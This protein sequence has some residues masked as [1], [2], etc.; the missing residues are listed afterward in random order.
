MR[1]AAFVVCSIAASACGGE[2]QFF[3]YPPLQN[4]KS[5]LIAVLTP[6][7][8]DVF[9]YEPEH[10]LAF[11]TEYP[12]DTPRLE[13]MTLSSRLEDEGLAAGTIVA[14][15]TAQRTVAELPSVLE[16]SAA[17]TANGGTWEE[18]SALD[19]R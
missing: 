14:S 2:K 18:A 10:A 17:P 5:A 3:H 1:R 12:I 7:S 13:A 6:D 19:P 15:G 4:A 9:G 11:R 8:I 16:L